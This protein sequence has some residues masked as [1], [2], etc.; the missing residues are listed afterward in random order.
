MKIKKRVIID[1]DNTYSIPNLPIDDGQTI[2][3]LKGR[4][5]IEIAGIT[6]TYG[7]GTI[8]EVFEATKWLVS[9]LGLNKIPILKGASAPGDYDTEASAWLAKVT[10][11]NPKQFH[12]LAIGTMTNLAGAKKCNPDFFK[13]L[14]RVAAM[15]GYLYPLPV[16]GW[17]KIPELNFSKDPDATMALFHAECPVTIMSAQICLQAPFGINELAPIASIN[18]A[19]YFYMLNYLMGMIKRHDGAQEYL[20]DLL[21]AVYLSYP[22]LFNAHQIRISNDIE[23]ISKGLLIVDE[24]GSLLTIPDHIKDIEMFY[25]IL[26]SAWTKALAGNQ[27][28]KMT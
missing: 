23:N 18:K 20:W 9:S 27:Q 10:D 7:N 17:N 13:N 21:P 4:E 6:C 15:G 12:L 24:N 5:D 1:C 8:E 14:A 16:R 2:M 26:Y 11:Q 22:E 25:S 28:G 3:Y 19:S